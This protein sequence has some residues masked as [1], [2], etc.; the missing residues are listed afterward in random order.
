M[1]TS[2]LGLAAVTVVTALAF[3][4]GCGGA[5]YAIQVNGAASKVAQAK[6]LGA[7][8]LAPYEYYYASEHLNKAMSEASE[9]DYSDANQ[10][11]NV[12]EEYADKAIKLSKEAHRGAGR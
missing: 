11:A 5:L 10:F 12:A 9:G 3:G 8:N 4:G 2:R 7:E 6:E 1:R